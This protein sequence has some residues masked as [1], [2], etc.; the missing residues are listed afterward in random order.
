MRTAIINWIC[1]L[2]LLCVIASNAADLA[3]LDELKILGARESNFRSWNAPAVHPKAPGPALDS[4]RKEIEP[5]LNSHCV[6]CHGPKK[7]KA[8]LRIDQLD[9]DLFAGKDVDWWLEIQ[10]V[11][12][13]GEMPPPEK[14]KLSGGDRA[15]VMEWLSTEIRLAS[16]ARRAGE[17]HSSF[18]RMTRYEYNYALQDLLGV[19]GDFARDLPPEAHSDDG[20]QNSSETLHISVSQLETYRR[21]ARKALMRAT[22]HGP[23]PP[24]LYWGVPMKRAAQIEWATQDK[25]L[26]ETKEKFKDD[27]EKQKQE[28]DRLLARFKH[29]HSG[30]HFKNLA[31]GRTAYH[32]WSYYS[33]KYAFKPSDAR[34][35]F[36][37]PVEQVAILPRGKALVVELGDRIPDDGTMR[38]RVQ[39]SR[40]HPKDQPVPSLQLEFGWKASNEGRARMRVSKSDIRVT[41]EPDAPTIYQWEVPLANIYPRNGVRG[42]SPMGV[43]SPSPSEYIRLVNSSASSGSIRIDH[44][45]VATPVYEQWPT[46]SHGRIFFASDNSD[47]E[48]VYA[49]EILTKFTYRAWRRHA[50]KEEIDKKLRLFLTMRKSCDTFE[51][52]MVE[53][54]AT[55][56]SSPEFLYLKREDVASRL[57]MF[58]WSSV[59]DERLLKLAI[60]G[61]LN[62]PDV[63]AGEV[64]R[65]LGDARAKRFAKHFVRQWLDMQLLDFVE[66]DDRHINLLLKEAMQQEP[67]LF[68]AEMLRRN[69]SVLDFI[70]SDYTMANERLASHYNVPDVFGNHFRRVNLNTGHR[71]GGLLTQAG[72]LAMNSSG[73]D[74]NPLKRGIWMLESLLN[75]PPPPP[76]PAVPEI[77]LTDPRIAKMTLKE[78]IEDHR[79]HPACMACHSK[80]DPWGIA[81]ENYDALGRWRNEIEGKPVDATSRLFN[82]EPLNG[83]DGLKRFLLKNRQDQFVRAM[84]HKMTVYALG[85]PLTFADRSGIEEITA[86]VRQQ[87]DG[88]AT[89]V[90]QVTTSK[91]FRTQ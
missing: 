74:S 57:S 84:T 59:P 61:R 41:A 17:G 60:E 22:V 66:T 56:L 33:A 91:L 64:K 51:Q 3:S 25:K 2:F 40:L 73:E 54:L 36:P 27:P 58:L 83:M 32:T 10:A 71:R 76:P 28:V 86:K 44:V 4:F 9:P 29:P 37:K 1:G 85:R 70:H 80:I 7:A 49:R 75:D 90:T 69:E 11:L 20:F 47:D 16:N 30:T 45:E 23:R 13:T 89:L 79:N 53:V 67:I 62:N 82:N 87:G 55:V 42:R 18:R 5:L 72:L 50:S 46:A 63:I 52:A 68:F 6:Q 43:H 19:P 24:L 81:F 35:E 48:K 14:S 88:L 38:V 78:R 26:E 39:A 21:I 77:D 34:P 65:M 8:S 12:G 31:T 15:K